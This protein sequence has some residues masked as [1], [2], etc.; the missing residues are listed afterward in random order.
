MQDDFQIFISYS[1]KDIDQVLI[2][3]ELLDKKGFNCWMAPYSI[4]P[5]SDYASEITPAIS[6]SKVMIAFLSTNFQNSIWTRK[7]VDLALNNK[8]I[9]IPWE[10]SQIELS[11]AYTFLF[12]NVQR[13]AAYRDFNNS[14]NELLNLLTKLKDSSDF[15][16]NDS[17]TIDYT[18]IEELIKKRKFVHAERL[19]LRKISENPEDGY[20]YLLGLLTQLEIRSIEELDSCDCNYENYDYYLKAIKF[21]DEETRQKIIIL[22]ERNKQNGDF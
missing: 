18:E 6:Q 13:I 2:V 16:I 17:I 22:C 10:L 7:E 15:E 19:I 14:F 20:L 12:S 9:I 3:K 8:V 11:K 5:G 1:S 4:P 21:L